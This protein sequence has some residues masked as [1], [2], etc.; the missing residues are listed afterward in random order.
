VAA[1]LGLGRLEAEHRQS[2][3]GLK[4]CGEIGDQLDQALLE[5]R[6]FTYLLHPPN[7]ADDG[8]RATLEEFI[9]GFARRTGLR[10]SIRISDQVDDASPDIQR[11][12]LRVVQEALAN[13]HR[14][15]GA[16]KVHVGAKLVAGRLVVR[17]RDDGRGMKR[18]DLSAGRQ[19]MGVGIPGMHARLQQFGGDLKIRTGT[20]GTSLLANVPL[21][22]PSKVA[23]LTC[24]GRPH[25]GSGRG[26]LAERTL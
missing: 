9:E 19:K 6:V 14:H 25:Q 2:P 20:G 23:V 16:L 15:A 3:T 8:L 21:A 12:I 4:A 7:L 22:E 13:V 18:A 24:R 11:A 26:G 10:S 1:S 5:L 17:I